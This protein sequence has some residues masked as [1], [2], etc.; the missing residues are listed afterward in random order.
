M[1][2]APPN[3]YASPAQRQDPAPSL[4]DAMAGTARWVRAASAVSLTSSGGLM[5]LAGV[6]A[7]E[8]W[9]SRDPLPW[10]AVSLY[11]WAAVTG[12]VLGLALLRHA[13]QLERATGDAGEEP[14][15]RAFA[16]AMTTWRIIVFVVVMAMSG[17]LGSAI[18]L[19]ASF[20]F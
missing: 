14:L 19:A 15:A 17:A 6:G 5:V 7:T 10:L 1:D 4:V 18:L 8:A 3:P 12:L 20:R 2:E 13:R 11:A 16:S 9:S